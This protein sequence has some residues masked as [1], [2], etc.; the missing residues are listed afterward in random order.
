VLRVGLTGGI[1]SGKSETSRC[2][3]ACGAVL[4]DADQAAHDVVAVGT[5]GLAK[6]VAE[7]GPE[8]LKPDGSLDRERVAA[9]VFADPEALKRLNAIVHPLVGE[10]M[11]ALAAEAPED[12]VLLYDVPL[13][14]ENNLAKGF[15]VVVVV[16]VP[17]GTQLDRLV[18][19][20]GMSEDDARA[21]MAHQ[22]TREQRLAIADIV[23]DNSGTL[24]DLDRQVR[25]A[26]VDLVQRAAT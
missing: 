23:I 3:V 13:I 7:F 15:D 11:A 6:V 18:R 19:F 4:I 20:R 16:D 1:G 24:D 22:A 8:V 10:R 25:V 9:I 12:A 14:A 26:W 21:R 5:P 2:F 17:P